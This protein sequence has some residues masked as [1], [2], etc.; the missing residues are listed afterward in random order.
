MHTLRQERLTLLPPAA[1]AVLDEALAAA[2]AALEGAMASQPHLLGGGGE[3]PLLPPRAIRWRVVHSGAVAVR[4]AADGL[5]STA[6][7]EQ[8]RLDGHPTTTPC[9]AGA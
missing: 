5:S 4:G 3:V 7:C 1:T 9:S 6:P 8:R 2:E